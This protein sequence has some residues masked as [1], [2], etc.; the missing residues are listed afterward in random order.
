MDLEEPGK[1]ESMSLLSPR[2]D[3]TPPQEGDVAAALPQT[4]ALRIGL[5]AFGGVLALGGAWFLLCSLLL[6]Q[7]VTL[8]LDR[9]SAAAAATHRASALWAAR[10]GAIRGDLF[11]QAA[12]SDASLLWLDRARGLDAASAAQVKTARANAETALA[13]APLNGA[14]WLFLAELP[15]ASGRAGDGLIPLQMSYFTAPN[16]P[17]LARPRIERALASGVPIDKDLQEF[18]KGDLR[19]ILANQ[20]RQKP[21]ILAA[22]KTAAP[23]N[24][25]IFE[26]LAADVDR[27]FS[28]ALGGE[29]PK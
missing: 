25:A 19:E 2:P 26:G 13:L 29:T 23:Q 11:A 14:A 18:M 21:A 8:P 3:R 7:A 20:P 15:R 16:D 1:V 22:Y 12:Y 4:S 17:A 9:A 24:Q 6:P 5:L 28:R 10:L 27:D